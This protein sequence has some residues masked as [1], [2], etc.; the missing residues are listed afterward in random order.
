MSPGL[1]LRVGDDDIKSFPEP[2]LHLALK[3]KP[4]NFPS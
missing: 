4:S 2:D 1:F 3:P